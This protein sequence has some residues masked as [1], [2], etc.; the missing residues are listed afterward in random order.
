MPSKIKGMR[1]NIEIL[2]LLFK[3]IRGDYGPPASG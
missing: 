2:R 1:A 3:T